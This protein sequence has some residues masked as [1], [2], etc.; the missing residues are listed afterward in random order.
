MSAPTR[1]PA[2]HTRKPFAAEAIPFKWAGLPP[3]SRGRRR[4]KKALG[5]LAPDFPLKNGE[6]KA[7][8]RLR[9]LDRARMGQ[10][11]FEQAV[12]AYLAAISVTVG[13]RR[14]PKA[15]NTR[16]GEKVRRRL[17]SVKRCIRSFE[18]P[19]DVSKPTTQDDG[20][21]VGVGLFVQLE[22]VGR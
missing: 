2:R 3:L 5:A 12:L 10:K 4:T 9:V 18:R 19:L 22:V 7:L 6:R 21:N 20:A 17:Q 8:A 15:P 14:I 16:T 11:R 13:L 1:N